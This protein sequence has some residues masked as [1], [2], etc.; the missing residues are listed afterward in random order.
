MSA[1]VFIHSLGCISTAGLGIQPILQ[2]LDHGTPCLSRPCPSH[3]PSSPALPLAGWIDPL[4]KPEV[5][6]GRPVRFGRL[7]RLSQLALLAAGNALSLDDGLLG[8]HAGVAL[9]T[10][11]GSHLTNE[12][13]QR[14]L[15]SEGLE[16]ASPALFAYTL[17]SSATGEISIHFALK[18]PCLTLA[19]GTCAG[20]SAI[21]AAA[22]L[23]ATGKTDWMLAG[24]ADTLSSTLI[25]SRVGARH[26][27]SEGAAFFLLGRDARRGSARV[28][29]L[30]QA[31]AKDALA[32]AEASALAQA[33]LHRRQINLRLGYDTTSDDPL[34][35][36]L[37][38][39]NAALPL[40]GIGAALARGGALPLLAT[41][42]FGDAEGPVAVLCLD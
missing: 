19:Q 3:I 38:H 20:L 37:G 10:A 24:G 27:P 26:I 29:G 6:T 28:A 7:D 32:R 40:F 11:H 5:W 13:F 12:L 30:G 14:G 22:D 15:Q 39:C 21:G 18:G 17:P 31:S 8:N 9:G 23:I 4:P 1:K 16:G 25:L 36:A 35:Q 33:G 41:D 42:A 2:M 34:A